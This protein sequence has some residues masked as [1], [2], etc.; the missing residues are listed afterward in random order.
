VDVLA[1]MLERIERHEQA[2]ARPVVSSDRNRH[3]YGLLCL[4]CGRCEWLIV[5][6]FTHN[7]PYDPS[8]GDSAGWALVFLMPVI[9]PLCAVISLAFGFL[10]YLFVRTRI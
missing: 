9:G 2:S 5:W 4:D 7:H 1:F 3:R 10:G 8:A 6:G